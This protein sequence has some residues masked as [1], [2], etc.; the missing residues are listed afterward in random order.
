MKVTQNTDLLPCKSSI[1]P[2]KNI[3]APVRRLIIRRRIILTLILFL[4]LIS[5]SCEKNDVSLGTL[6]VS[7]DGNKKSFNNEAKAEWITVQG[8]YGLTISGYK[9]DVGSSNN[10]SITIAS[11]HNI[12]T[13]TYINY[14]SGN[15]VEIKYF[16][17]LLFTWDTWTSSNATVTIS[18]INSTHVKGTFKGTLAYPNSTSTK[19]LTGGVFNISF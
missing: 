4:T 19:E 2:T 5:T 12:S 14:A 13:G 17:N 7:V 3:I 18:E 15:A 9:G 1:N 16:I 10:I 6:S 8:G 11:P